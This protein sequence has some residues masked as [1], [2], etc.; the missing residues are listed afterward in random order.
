[1]TTLN[2]ICIALISF[3]C[4]HQFRQW[5]S[6]PSMDKPSR[7]RETFCQSFSTTTRYYTLALCYCLCMMS[8]YWSL[9]I[10]LEWMVTPD[11]VDGLP[12]WLLIFFVAILPQLPL[13]GK[14][15][16][17][18]R[19]FFQRHCFSPTLPSAEEE[20]VLNQLIEHEACFQQIGRAHV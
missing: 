14:A 5:G 7:H 13:F 11:M 2:L 19:L 15:M 18:L 12:L 3:Y 6:I 10:V 4:W 9:L 20:Q 1:M 16:V 8:I 17:H